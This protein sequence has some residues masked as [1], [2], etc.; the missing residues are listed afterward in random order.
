MPRRRSMFPKQK[1]WAIY[2][3]PAH[4][5]QPDSALFGIIPISHKCCHHEAL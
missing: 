4:I 3:Y 2:K 5:P 1:K